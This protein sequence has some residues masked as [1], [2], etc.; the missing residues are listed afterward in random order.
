MIQEFDIPIFKKTYDL[1]RQFHHLRNKAAKQ[2]RFTIYL[3]TENILL[4]IIEGILEASELSKN[5]K[6][7]ILKKTSLN[8][9]LLRVF[10]RLLKDT[11]SID[12][13]SYALLEENIDE[14]GR[15]LGGWIK[16]T[17]EA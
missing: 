7:P 5:E 14:I 13:K 6:L 11:K 4:E 15:M 12:L 1:Y 17:K 10:V 3:K 16:S 9:N 8:L 2:D